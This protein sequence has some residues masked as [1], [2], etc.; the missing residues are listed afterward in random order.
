MEIIILIQTI[1][2]YISIASCLFILSLLLYKRCGGDVC[3]QGFEFELIANLTI[4]SVFT[5]FAYISGHLKDQV[6][7]F[8]LICKAQAF[9]MILFEI[10]QYIWSTL[11]LMFLYVNIVY[12]EHNK[13]ISNCIRFKN[14]FIGYG[15]PLMFSLV[16]YFLDILGTSGRWCWL[17]TDNPSE[18]INMFE[19]FEFVL[20]WLLIFT[21][22]IILLILNKKHNQSSSEVRRVHSYVRYIC[23]YPIVQIICLFPPTISR[24]VRAFVNFDN[25]ILEIIQVFLIVLQGLFYTII[26]VSN[27]AV[28][29]VLM[30][31]FAS[32]FT[33][34]CRKRKY[35]QKTYISKIFGD[36]TQEELNTTNAK[37]DSENII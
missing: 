16:C 27:P 3:L 4:S 31:S 29:K 26:Y 28:K 19:I 6:V 32:F 22:C 30:K 5:T 21:N 10:S 13:K 24:L 12:D 2:G 25:Y 8:D 33:C 36:R 1:I 7:D 35:N 11:L 9:S 15:L 20:I 34:R 23:M 18:T 17:N 37:E 14:Y